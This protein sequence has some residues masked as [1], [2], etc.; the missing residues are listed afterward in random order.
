MK[1]HLFVGLG[2]QGG[3]SLAELRKVIEERA[4]NAEELKRSGMKWDFLSIDSNSDVWRASKG[5]KYFGKDVSLNGNQMLQMVR[6][7]ETGGLSIRPDVAPWIGDQRLIDRYLGASGEIPGAN[8]R[9]R[10]GRLL[11]HRLRPINV[12][13]ICL[14]LLQAEQGVGESLI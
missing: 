10:L 3:R 5:W 6:M 9:R 13:S 8:Q 11:S 1:N 7:N 14:P 12:G 4:K 2:G